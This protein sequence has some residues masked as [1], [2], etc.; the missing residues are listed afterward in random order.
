M[1]SL[2]SR[3]R[4]AGEPHLHH[5]RV[6]RRSLEVAE[7]VLRLFTELDRELYREGF[8]SGSPDLVC[9]SRAPSNWAHAENM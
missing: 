7:C 3:A 1:P 6:E 5:L 2:C 9:E 4:P 8:D